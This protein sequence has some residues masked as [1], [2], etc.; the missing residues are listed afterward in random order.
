MS[1]APIKASVA[2]FLILVILSFPF[3]ASEVL[4]ACGYDSFCGRNS[5]IAIV[6]AMI[7]AS[8][9]SALLSFLL[10]KILARGLR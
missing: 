2:L 4:D 9:V 3:A 5:F 7:I 1:I 6:L 10:F 8:S